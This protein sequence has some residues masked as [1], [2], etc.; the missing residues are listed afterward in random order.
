MPIGDDYHGSYD[1]KVGKNR[2]DM[3]PVSCE[4]CI[5]E[6]VTNLGLYVDFAVSKTP[7]A[8]VFFYCMNTFYLGVFFLST[9]YLFFSYFCLVL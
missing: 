7:V 4:C 2:T 3:I 8:D 5:G 6:V 9:H 1:V